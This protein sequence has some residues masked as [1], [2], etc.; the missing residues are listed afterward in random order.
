MRFGHDPR[1]LDGAILPPR[2]LA[3][4]LLFVRA[5]LDNKGALLEQHF[6]GLTGRAGLTRFTVSP[7][8]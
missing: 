8:V 1:P 5:P 3:T 6:D 2:H 4:L 7:R